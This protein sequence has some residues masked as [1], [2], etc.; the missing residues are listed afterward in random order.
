M[1]KIAIIIAIATVGATS[2]T[3]C[4]KEAKLRIEAPAKTLAGF[5]KDISV[6]D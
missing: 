3:S 6:A 4:K 2:L 1:K 5:K